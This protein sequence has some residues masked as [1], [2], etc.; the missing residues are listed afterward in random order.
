MWAYPRAPPL[1]SANAT[2]RPGSGSGATS[3]SVM[4]SLFP[5]RGR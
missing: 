3:E 5:A 2:R 1:P 4:D